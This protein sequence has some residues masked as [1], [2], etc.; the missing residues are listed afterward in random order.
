[1]LK[2]LL[3]G[4][5]KTVLL[6]GRR[7]LEQTDQAFRFRRGRHLR[8]ALRFV[9]ERSLSVQVG[10]S[11][12]RRVDIIVYQRVKLLTPTYDMSVFAP[13]KPTAMLVGQPASSGDGGCCSLSTRGGIQRENKSLQLKGQAF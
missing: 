9:L 5:A 8:E 12:A 7:A 13:R 3:S 1:M 10:R 11:T 4:L 6:E 2:Y